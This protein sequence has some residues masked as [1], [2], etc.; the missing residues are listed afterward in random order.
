[1]SD[2]IRTNDSLMAAG[3][4]KELECIHQESVPRIVT[5]E[6]IR[7]LGLDPADEQFYMSFSAEDRK[8]ITRKVGIRGAHTFMK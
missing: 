5:I 8:K 4:E 6:N 2:A 1:M 3:V 7:V